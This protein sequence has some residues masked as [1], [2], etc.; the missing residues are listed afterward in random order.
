MAAGPQCCVTARM[1]VEQRP[2]GDEPHRDYDDLTT[3]VD[4]NRADI[5]A[6]QAA[7]LAATGRADALDARATG[8]STRLDDL[9]ARFDVDREVIAQ[10][11]ADGLLSAEHAAHLEHALRS[12]RRIGAAIGII[13]AH[14]HESEENAFK[15]LCRASQNANRKISLVADDLVRTG[16]VSGVP[17]V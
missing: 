4:R 12:S 15:S 14:R 17:A 16:D 8:Q 10:L 9:E 7:L 3:E 2:N 13:M 1:T 6:L 5:D 11:Q